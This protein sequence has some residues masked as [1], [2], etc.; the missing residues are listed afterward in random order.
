MEQLGSTFMPIPNE[1][2]ILIPIPINSSFDLSFVDNKCQ[3]HH[4]YLKESSLGLEEGIRFL[5][6]MPM[7][8]IY[9]PIPGF[10]F[11]LSPLMLA[12]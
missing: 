3:Y 4:L 5:P 7:T 8:T 10:I 2:V 11:F 9:S 1:G 12:D 6:D